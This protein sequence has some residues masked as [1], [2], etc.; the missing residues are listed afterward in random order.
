MTF[1]INLFVELLCYSISN[2]VILHK[3]KFIEDS[4]WCKRTTT[5]WLLELF[6]INNYPNL[7]QVGEGGFEPNF[8]FME[9]LGNA[10]KLQGSW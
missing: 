8:S 4:M 7:Q 6:Y 1:Y 3:S 10:T 5:F 9:E 2:A